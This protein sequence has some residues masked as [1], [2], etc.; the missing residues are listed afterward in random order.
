MPNK[1]I[2]LI[3]PHAS[4][5]TMLIK[6]LTQMGINFIP[7]YTTRA[8]TEN[9]RL[10]RTTVHLDKD[11]F[12]KQ[13]FISKYTYKGEYY[14]VLKQDVLDSLQNYPVSIVILSVAG[15]KQ[16]GKLL[17]N[18][19]E[20]VYVMSD[21]VTMVERMLKMGET[22]EDIKHHLEYAEN[23]NEFDAW[24]ISTHVIKNVTVP[25]QALGQM[26]TIMGLTQLV[27]RERFLALTQK[28]QRG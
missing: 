6:K 18:A 16:L 7:S 26:L 14:G 2:A 4:G 1:I 3:G 13:N 27:P 20:T 15:V 17:K 8:L 12:F 9:D 23:N 22:N 11:E 28:I 10:D 25:E 19:F 5:K 21:Y 24:K